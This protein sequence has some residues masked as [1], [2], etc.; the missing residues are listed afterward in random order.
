MKQNLTLKQTQ[1][2]NLSPQL[3]QAIK[4]L[5]CSQLDFEIEIKNY[6][7]SNPLLEIAEDA[8]SLSDAEATT[9]SLEDGLSKEDSSVVDSDI[10]IFD[11]DSADWQWSSV[12]GHNHEDETLDMML[13]IAQP[14][15][16]RDS[17]LS[18]VSE[19]SLTFRD[20]A[21]ITL[22]ID[23]LDAKGFLPT[24][25]D[26]ILEN[27]PL[28]L[29][30]LE[31]E[32]SFA[33]SLLQQFEPAGVG[34]RDLRESLLIQTKNRPQDGITLLAQ[35]IIKDHFDLLA[36]KQKKQLIQATGLPEEKIDE[37]LSFIASLN[38]YPTS[39]LP[40]T[41]IHYVSPDIKVV[42]T[43]DKKWI[44]ILNKQNQ[45]RIQLNQLYAQAV[46]MT[47]GKTEL[48]G[49]LQEAQWLLKSIEQRFETIYSIATEIVKIQQ[50]FFDQGEIAMKPLTLKDIAN[51][52][53]I[54][55]STV[56]RACTQKY[57]ICDRGLYE[58]RY[59]FNQ[60]IQLSHDTDESEENITSNMAIK[61]KIKNLIAQEDST[62]PL[63]DDK[64]TQLLKEENIS[65][66]R[67]TVTKYRESMH[68]PTTRERKN[69]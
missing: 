4:L 47:E 49:T 50:D 20:K 35:F 61:A 1:Q 31:E 19:H 57:L 66:A 7:E 36:T 3:K 22:L 44:A 37:A 43:K 46:A 68:I 6:L 28:D 51:K 9:I 38:P 26:E 69:K 8:S 11:S 27:L 12:S 62:K 34:A 65:I 59:F 13:N 54:H 14:F 17:L 25:L 2:L 29:M 10:E 63:S 33:L 18:Q 41:E 53:N 21:L 5:L 16:L 42:K 67:R 56:S 23:E 15:S 64:I 60:G 39:N 48:S 58:L 32:L 30:V 24:S 55:E 40:T 45:P 52:L